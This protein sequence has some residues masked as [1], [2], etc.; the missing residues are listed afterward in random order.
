M[1]RIGTAGWAIPARVRDRFPATGATL[2]RYAARFPAAEINSTFYRSHRPQT[3]ERWAASVP[4]AFRFALKLPKAITH[5]R[6]LLDVDALVLRFLDETSGLGTRIGPLLIQLPPSLAFDADAARTVLALLRSRGG[7]PIACEPRHP[8]WF[9]GEAN[10]LLSD[11]EVARVAADPARVP[12]AALPGG[13]RSFAYYR[14]HGSPRIYFSEYGQAFVRDLARRLISEPAPETWCIFD[15][16]A[17][18]AAA[19]DALLMQEQLRELCGP[20]ASPADE[21]AVSRSGPA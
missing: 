3:Y 21:T 16:T 20:Q 10:R 5:E 6:R 17:S 12:A 2:A 9:D 19:V 1:I 14:L 13:S 4:D 15:N 8:S 7:G 11:F 18:G